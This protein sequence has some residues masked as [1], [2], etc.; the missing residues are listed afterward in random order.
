MAASTDR[1][2]LTFV[3][4]FGD[5][6]NRRFRSCV[7]SRIRQLQRCVTPPAVIRAKGSDACRCH[8]CEPVSVCLLLMDSVGTVDDRRSC[9]D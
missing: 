3:T 4:V 2:V 8:N 6:Y 1:L 5:G 9:S 7:M